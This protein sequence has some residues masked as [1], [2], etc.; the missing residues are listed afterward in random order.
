MPNHKAFL[1]LVLMSVV[2]RILGDDDLDVPTI[3]DAPGPLSIGKMIIG[4]L[5]GLFFI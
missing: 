2:I 3:P 1:K 5:K 4:S